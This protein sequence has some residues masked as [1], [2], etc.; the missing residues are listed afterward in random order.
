M[1]NY[2]VLT[3][4]AVA[5]SAVTLSLQ[6]QADETHYCPSSTEITK[7]ACQ[8]DSCKYSAPGGWTGQ[9]KHAPGAFTHVVVREKEKSKGKEDKIKTVTMDYCSYTHPTNTDTKA[10]P[11]NL[12]NFRLFNKID[13]DID[14][15]S[16]KWEK[17]EKHGKKYICKSN[18]NAVSDCEFTLKD[19]HAH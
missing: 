17:E 10:K 16:G 9:S 5:I 3:I 13:V 7:G 11:K 8:K 4:I 18:S 12:S 1:L 19:G 15:E 6:V 14:T 2:K